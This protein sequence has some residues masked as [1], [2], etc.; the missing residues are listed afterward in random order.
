MRKLFIILAFFCAVKSNAQCVQTYCVD[1]LPV[2]QDTIPLVGVVTGFTPQFVLWTGGP[3]IDSAF[4]LSTVARGVTPGMHVFTLLVESK[5][6]ARY[7][8][9][10]T[11]YALPATPI[12]MIVQLPPV[13]CP[14][15]L[16][17]RTAIGWHIGRAGKQTFDYDDGT[18]SNQ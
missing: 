15:P 14:A 2:G 12:P 11:V 9:S 6:G 17:Q 5:A 8:A 16:K 4:S 1:T 10:D 13:P 3:G 7:I 18:I